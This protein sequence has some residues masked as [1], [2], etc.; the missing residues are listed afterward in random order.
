[1][2]YINQFAKDIL[3]YDKECKLNRFKFKYPKQEL[4]GKRLGLPENNENNNIEKKMTEMYTKNSLK[5]KVI[6]RD[7]GVKLLIDSMLGSGSLMGGNK[8]II[9]DQSVKAEESCSKCN[10]SVF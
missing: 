4:W 6:S 5:M 3:E 9:N 2:D 8:N 1:M 7:D 10:C